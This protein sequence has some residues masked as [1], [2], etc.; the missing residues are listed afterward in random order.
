[1]W[2]T[3]EDNDKR[4]NLALLVTQRKDIMPL[5][6]VNLLT[7]LKKNRSEYSH[8]PMRM[9]DNI[10]LRNAIHCSHKHN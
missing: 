7:E 10:S 2:L 3:T 5:L 8:W 1:M 6:N 4:E 9:N